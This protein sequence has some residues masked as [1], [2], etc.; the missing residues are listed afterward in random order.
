MHKYRAIVANLFDTG[1]QKIL[2]DKHTLNPSTRSVHVPLLRHGLL[3]HL[4]IS[5]KEVNT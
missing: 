5:T 3:L 4:L 1:S 2:E